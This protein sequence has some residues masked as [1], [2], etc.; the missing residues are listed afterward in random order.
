MRITTTILCLLL[1]VQIAMGQHHK[2]TIRGKVFDIDSEMPLIGVNILGINNT[3]TLFCT[4]DIDGRFKLP[5]VSI[6]RINI[7][8]TYLGYEDKIIPNVVVNSAK[9]VIINIGLT[10]STI[11][12]NEVVV[13]AH[14]EKGRAIDPM[15]L[16]SAQSISPEETS[17]YA[18]GFND[19]SRIVS[20]FAGVN[21]TGDG[22]NDIIIRGNSPKY[23]QWRL[24]GMQITNPNHF[25]D[26]SAIGGSV[27]TL[28]NNILD[29][30][31][32]Y[33]GA[34]SAEYGDVLSGVYDV[35][36]RN[37]NNEKYEAVA[38]V[39]LLGMDLTFEG[40]F[41]K[42][43]GGS[44][45]LNYRYSTA[46]L[47]K[48]LGLLNDVTG[49]PTFQDA[50]FKVVLPT[51]K[52]GVFSLYGLGGK[53][54]FLWEDVDPQTWVTP[55]DAFMR[56]EITEDYNKNA[57]LVNLGANHTIN[58]TDHS[59]IKTGILHSIEGI[60][61]EIFENIH[62][63][64]DGIANKDS[65]IERRSNFRNDLR[66]TVSR[67]ASTYHH[68]INAKHKVIVGSKYARF[69]YTV[70]Q[71]RLKTDNTARQS[72][73]DFDETIGTWRNFV[74]YK[75]NHND[76]LTIVAGIH[77]MNVLFN[78]KSTIEPRLAFEWRASDKTSFHAG[79]GKHS[80]MESIHN[81]FTQIEQTDGS[82][83]EPNLDL[84]LLKSD[85]YII[86]LERR[87]GSNI[88]AKIEA[89][90]QNLY[91]LPVEN[92][93]SSTYATINESL[94]FQYVDLVNA[95]KGKN[96]G[97]ELTLER[98]FQDNFYYLLNTSIYESKYTALDGVERDTR[99]NG[100]YIINIL[101]GK[102]FTELGKSGNQSLTLNV[103]AF[104]SGGK[105][106]TP[107]LRDENGHLAVDAEHG[108]FYD[109]SRPFT[110]RLDDLYQVNLSASY[111]WN[112]RKTTHELFINLDNATN[113]KGKI[114]EY[115]DVEEEGSI[116]HLTQFG[117][118]PNLMYRVYF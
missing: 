21:N 16:L 50:A 24:E 15:S 58:I 51:K 40:P 72:L 28:N 78:D 110:E 10:E 104:Y 5:P 41:S 68:K 7:A 17:R 105:R 47:V 80:T 49:V 22:G 100:N 82:T 27:S 38:G 102:E 90:Y 106:I 9:E 45:L 89:Y 69:G 88:T 2:Q 3:D 36:L 55:G 33:T 81:Y 37:G 52:L 79:Y 77:N 116:G 14:K 1:A 8:V 56:P 113:H 60:E 44:F 115:Y 95:G 12:I 87:I 43:Y 62:P 59:Y 112:K 109:N 4:S 20:N 35:K 94:D 64:E 92:D 39:G 73:L 61:D 101:F 25:G 67:I 98:Y 42:N 117:I 23:M 46:G 32:F 118:F 85:H 11:R 76:Q 71:S 93:L 96:Y 83:I 18:G 70:A 31:D 65:L 91:D 26:Q 66:K 63:L 99:F 107:L 34:F 30:S 29:N 48:D 97:I 19:P 75:Y 111:K 86:G 114:S 54:D 53:S 74:N 6:G 108:I 84:D 103:K 13:V 57:H